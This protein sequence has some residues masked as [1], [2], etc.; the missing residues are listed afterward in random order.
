M[1]K[2]VEVGMGVKV[3]GCNTLLGVAV[4]VGEMTAGKVGGINSVSS[5][6]NM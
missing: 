4:G 3:P 2:E 6:A 5:G 1:A